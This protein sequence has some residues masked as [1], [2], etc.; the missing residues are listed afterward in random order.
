MLQ[1]P[2]VAAHF[3]VSALLNR[4]GIEHGVNG[5]SG[6]LK[7]D[8]QMAEEQQQAAMAQA[9]QSAAPAFA[10]AA[11]SAASQDPNQGT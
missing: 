5:L 10:D 6:L 1:N 11:I 2:T 8:E 9:A 4:L 7:T 3:N